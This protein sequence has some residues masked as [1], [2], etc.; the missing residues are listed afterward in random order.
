MPRSAAVKQLR[1]SNIT[2]EFIEI[3]PEMAAELLENNSVNRK[4]RP[5]LVAAYSRDMAT[6]LWRA[7]GE[8]VKISRTGRLLD[9]QH[10]LSAIIE[11][12]VPTMML[13]V[14]GLDDNDQVLM[15]QGAARTANDAVRLAGYTNSAH[16]SSIARWLLMCPEPSANME[17]A[18]K[19]KASTAQILQTLET[20]PDIE[21]A[22]RAYNGLRTHLPGSPTAIGYCWLQMHRVDPTDCSYFYTAFVDLT[23]KA[24]HDPRK[25]ALR[26]LQSMDKEAG[27]KSS[28]D[29]AIA[30]VS[31]LTRSW[32]A[33]RRDEEL[34]TITAYGKGNKVI[35]PAKLI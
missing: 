13:V 9:G 35:A 7:T 8:A 6:G 22:A 14:R 32:N 16:T 23:F 17:Q 5:R 29:K 20:N 28:K 24:L 11:S 12:G 25:A 10:R 27:S 3:T 19:A 34:N 30:T 26:R 21:E 4:L 33:W 18:L 31:V 1:P 15:D 2:T